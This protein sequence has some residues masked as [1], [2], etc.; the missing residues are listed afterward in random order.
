MNSETRDWLAGLREFATGERLRKP[1]PDLASPDAAQAA[2]RS[3]IGAHLATRLAEF[4]D[5]GEA[6][7]AWCRAAS[8][9]PRADEDPCLVITTSPAGM[10][11]VEDLLESGNPVFSTLAG[12][13]ATVTELEYRLWCIR[14]PDD[15]NRLHV[16]AWSWLKT[17]LPEQRRAEFA[18]HPLAEGEAFWLH[19]TGLAGAGS[20]D[21][22]DCHLWRW[23]GRH[24]ALLEAFVAER[25]LARLDER[26]GRGENGLRD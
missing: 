21:R 15:G 20:A 11:A 19:R 22:R 12:R 5:V 24:A 8:A 17:R 26:R 23:N 9:A 4:D 10:A 18:R 14:R 6:R 7:R 16:N 13:I 2:E 1:L 3:I 25:S